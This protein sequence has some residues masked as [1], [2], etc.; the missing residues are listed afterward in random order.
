[1]QRVFRFDVV[2]LKAQ[3]EMRFSTKTV[4]FRKTAVFRWKKHIFSKNR[5]FHVVSLKAQ[6]EMWFLIENRSF[7]ENHGF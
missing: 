6:T 5:S 7:A 3:T 4:V 1:M 2:S